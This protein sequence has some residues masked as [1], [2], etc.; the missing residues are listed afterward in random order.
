MSLDP[1]EAAAVRRLLHGLSGMSDETT[2]EESP[3]DIADHAIQ[4]IDQLEGEVERLRSRVHL[5]RVFGSDRP[6][7]RERKVAV[8]EHLRDKAGSKRS[9][10]SNVESDTVAAIADVSARTARTYMDE[11]AEDV[12]GCHLHRRE[13]VA[14]G[15]QLRITLDEYRAARGGSPA[16]ASPPR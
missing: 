11:I 16:E 10:K 2:E 15:K 4:R 5:L 1:L 13:G 8:V 9:G 14:T 6:E 3:T 12:P 7:K